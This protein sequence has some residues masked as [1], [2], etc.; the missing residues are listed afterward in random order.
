MD[1]GTKV[2]Q[3]YTAVRLM[4]KHNI[5]PAFFLQFGF[6]GE[7]LQDIQSTIK[8]LLDCMPH[9]VGISVS[10]PLPGTKFYDM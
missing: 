9:D 7:T 5:K 2:E 6:L 3:I 10:Y 4:K 1:K 8:M